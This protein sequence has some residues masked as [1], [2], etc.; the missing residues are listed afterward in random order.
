MVVRGVGEVSLPLRL[1]RV[2]CFPEG[3]G[4]VGRVA[5]PRGLISS[6][7]GAFGASAAWVLVGV[8]AVMSAGLLGLRVRWADGGCRGSSRFLERRCGISER[9]VVVC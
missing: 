2:P 4:D 5:H 3:V 1:L 9:S 6:I 8:V 7:V